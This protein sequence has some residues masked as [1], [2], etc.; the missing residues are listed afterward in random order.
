MIYK[1]SNHTQDTFILWLDHIG[2]SIQEL[3]FVII[4]LSLILIF[5]DLFMIVGLVITLYLLVFLN[6]KTKAEQSFKPKT[7]KPYLKAFSFVFVV[8]LVLVIITT[9]Y[10]FI[11]PE[12]SFWQNAL[13]ILPFNL[14]ILGMFFFGIN[15]KDFSWKIN[16]KQIVLIIAMYL[17]LRP[18]RIYLLD[19]SVTQV[20]FT[21]FS[22]NF[23]YNIYNPAF[24]EEIMFR[25]LLLTG[26][27]NYGFTN[28]KA[29]IIHSIIFGLIHVLNKNPFDLVVI[30][31]T[32]MQA[33]IGFLLGKLYLKT[34]SLTPNILLHAIYNVI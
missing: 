22:V 15:F 21:Y 18:L 26:L 7:Q 8:Y 9:R 30:L 20:S 28:K 4:T 3:V 13:A 6:Y 16:R 2:F 14:S 27:V 34:K 1:F 25:G 24:I 33:Y 32:S 11:S 5:N 12:N 29:N 31:S 23:L 19:D 17:I 10:G